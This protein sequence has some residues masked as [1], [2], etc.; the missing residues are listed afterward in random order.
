MLRIRALR[1]SDGRSAFSTALEAAISSGRYS[2]LERGLVRP[3]ADERERL[4]RIFGVPGTSLFK[5]V[6][7]RPRE[8]TPVA[9]Q[10]G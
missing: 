1:L 4:A 8:R 2:Y 9:M 10:A 3:T 7:L 6:V 5:P